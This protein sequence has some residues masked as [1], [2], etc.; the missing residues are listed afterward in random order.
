MCFKEILTVRCEEWGGDRVM[1]VDCCGVKCGLGW[2]RVK[3]P[4]GG[5][6]AIRTW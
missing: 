4:G 1:G 5:E 3:K 6:M 2:R